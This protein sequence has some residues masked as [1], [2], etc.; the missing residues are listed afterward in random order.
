VA[1]LKE[2]AER[3]E[4]AAKVP[5]DVRWFGLSTGRVRVYCGTCESGSTLEPGHTTADLIKWDR[6][7]RGEPE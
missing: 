5:C 3:T 7:H 6:Q 1:E 4:A 2:G